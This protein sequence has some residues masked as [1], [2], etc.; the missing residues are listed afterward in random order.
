MN[1]INWPNV[2]GTIAT[3]IGV[4]IIVIFFNLICREH[5]VEQYYLTQYNNVLVIKAD[6]EWM[7]DEAIVLD[8]CI[9]YDSAIALTKKLNQSLTKNK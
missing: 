8:R 2:L 9:S 1:I 3:M 7:E 4:A 5:H 6:I